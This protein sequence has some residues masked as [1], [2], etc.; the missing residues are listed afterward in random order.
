MVTIGVVGLGLMGSGIARR[1]LLAG[2]P[3]TGYNRTA[4]K[5]QRLVDA[6][7][8][9]ADSPRAVAEVA[10]ITLSMVTD[11][12]ALQAVA[13]GPDGIL[14]GLGPGKTYVDMSTVNPEVSRALAAR[15]RERGAG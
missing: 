13:D 12:A 11:T 7:M 4:A 3:V 5:A 1:L 10:E 2:H 6:G 8:R 14:A 15:V 9:R